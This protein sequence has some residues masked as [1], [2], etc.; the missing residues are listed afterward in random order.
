MPRALVLDQ[1]QNLDQNGLDSNDQTK[2]WMA[3]G[4]RQKPKMAQRADR[5]CAGPAPLQLTVHYA[6]LRAP[7]ESEFGEPPAAVRDH[8]LQLH[9]LELLG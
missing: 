8:L 4:G 7:F 2:P 9:Q 3:Q 6:V 5:P 1:R